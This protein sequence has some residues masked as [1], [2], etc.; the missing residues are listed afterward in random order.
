MTTDHDT[1]SDGRA[2][3]SRPERLNV[4]Y[5]CHRFPFPP[6]R[7]G[8]IRPFNM[9]RHLSDQGHRVTVA[10][11]TRSDQEQ[12]EGQGLE[13]HC[14]EI[15]SARVNESA[16][17]ARTWAYLPSLTPSSMGY[18]R[19]DSLAR[20]IREAASRQSF[21]LIMVHCSSVAQYVTDIEGTVKILD[22]GDMDSQKW[23]TYSRH[24]RFPMSVGYG[25][26]G[27]KLERAERAL[28]RQFD[29][30]TCTTR[31]EW[32]TLESY[33]TGVATDW[34]P[35]GVDTGYFA[36]SPESYDPDTVCFVGRMDYFPN[37][38]AMFEFCANVL[39]RLRERRPTVK[40]L[41]VGADPSPKVRALAK[42][43]GV[44]VTGSVPDVRPYVCGAALTVAPLLIAR[45]TQNK[46]LESMAMGVPVVAS[47][48]AAGGVDAV[49]E[50]HL[51][52]ASD[53]E[54]YTLQILRLLEAPDLRERM[55]IA[56][57]ERMLSNHDWAG[58]MAR[59]DGI[60]DRA[61]SAV[62]G[63]SMAA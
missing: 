1:S 13:N 27:W 47:G 58:S 7:G 18:F 39:P 21:D 35:N 17:K 28:A 45:G 5:V 29:V 26:E 19:S 31:A 49:P 25:L 11:L 40:L 14:A 42:L 56:G 3:T 44:E 22:Y 30:C 53:A 36:P 34:F 57:R 4:L 6:K 50:E 55:S 43:P 20:Q 52:T 15:L 2:N 62:L 59:L 33:A 9:I 63:P 16:A 61:L 48:E 38:Q 12:R 51:L 24:T 37:Q 46:M 32:Q 54:G 41:I 10:S 60:I 23:L 8:K